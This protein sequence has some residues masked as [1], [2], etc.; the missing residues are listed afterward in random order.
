M[1]KPYKI[2]FQGEIYERV[3]SNN[4]E[5]IIREHSFLCNK[6]EK[7]MRQAMGWV[8]GGGNGLGKSKD[9]TIEDYNKEI[10]ALKVLV[11]ALEKFLR[12]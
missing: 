6:T 2:M 1:D 8:D 3:D 10:K 4:R 11:S 7:L 9:A 5:S 12:D